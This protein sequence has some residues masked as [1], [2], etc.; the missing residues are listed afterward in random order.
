MLL[1]FGAASD[2]AL[3]EVPFYF[4]HVSSESLAIVAITEST[5]SLE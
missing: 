1:F 2:R 4:Q 5:D 3:K